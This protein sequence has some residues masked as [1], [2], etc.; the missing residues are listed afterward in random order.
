MDTNELDIE[1]GNMYIHVLALE[2]Q[3]NAGIKQS[4]QPSKCVGLLFNDQKNVR[5]VVGG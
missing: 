2:A 5:W 1:T 4:G 3:N